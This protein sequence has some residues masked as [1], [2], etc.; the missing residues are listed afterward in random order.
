MVTTNGR[1][2]VISK[3]T[4]GAASRLTGSFFLFPMCRNPKITEIRM[5]IHGIM[6]E[7]I[8]TF[9]G[10]MMI[11]KTIIKLGGTLLIATPNINCF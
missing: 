8:E 2:L 5:M 9:E 7:L 10:I 6:S 1:A 4:P 3:L 11:P